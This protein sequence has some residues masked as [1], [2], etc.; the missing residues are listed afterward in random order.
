MR[1]KGGWK[2]SPGV[3]LGVSLG[4]VGRH[5]IFFSRLLVGRLGTIGIAL[6]V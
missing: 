2:V 3:S 4:V 6:S 1:G 5:T